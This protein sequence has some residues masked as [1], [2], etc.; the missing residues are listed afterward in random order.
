MSSKI[1]IDLLRLESR[2]FIAQNGRRQGVNEQFRGIKRTLLKTMGSPS[3]NRPKNANMIMVT[4]V[5]PNEGKTFSAINL[6]LSIAFEQDKT[7]LLVDSDVINPSINK[8]LDF[9]VEKGMIE[10]LRGDFDD[11]G[12]VLVHTNIENLKIIPAGKPSNITNELLASDRMKRLTDELSTRYAD[13]VI[14]FDSPP[15]LGVTETPII[16]NL[17][18]Q[19]VIVVEENVTSLS[20]LKIATKN[21]N[22]DIA[23]GVIMNKS[24]RADKATYMTSDYNYSQKGKV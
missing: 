11:I 18:G 10:Y 17:M 16:T 20:E 24:T 14:I 1:N 4:S 2:G 3:E 9:K 5:S 6:A 13:R 22:R 21:I 7:V 19:V 23:T 12:D 15:L 8:T